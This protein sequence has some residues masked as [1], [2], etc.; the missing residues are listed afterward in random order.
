MPTF[1]T[2]YIP[3]ISKILE[4]GQ[5]KIKGDLTEM[6]TERTSAINCVVEILNFVGLGA[7]I[8]YDVLGHR[9]HSLLVEFPEVPLS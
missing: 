5:K 8:L 2:V 7:D 4:L 6:I 1:Q 9:V 3:I